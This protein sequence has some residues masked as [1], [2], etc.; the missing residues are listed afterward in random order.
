MHKCP[1]AEL[2]IRARCRSSRLAENGAQ[3]DLRK[4]DFRLPPACQPT[5]GLEHAVFLP[6]NLI[7]GFFG[8]NF[9]FL[10]LIHNQKAFWWTFSSMAGIAILTFLFFWRKR[11]IAQTGQ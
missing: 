4:A 5:P 9:E 8:M 6:L 11:Y 2:Y 1:Y 10:P 7:T 3:L